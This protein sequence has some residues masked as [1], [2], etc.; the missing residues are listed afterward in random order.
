VRNDSP[1]IQERGQSL[2]QVLVVAG[3]TAFLSLALATMFNFSLRGQ[4]AVEVRDAVRLFEGEVINLLSQAETCRQN[5]SG[6]SVTSPG[7]NLTR[8]VRAD[9]S[10]MFLANQIYQNNMLRFVSAHIGAFVPDSSSEP[11]KGR[12]KLTLQLEPL[13]DPVGPRVYMRDIRILG[14]IDSTGAITSCIAVATSSDGVWQISP[15]NPNDI[16]YMAGQVGV[17]MT[18][19]SE[20]LSVAG[21]VQ[22]TSGGFKFPD[23]TIQESAGGGVPFMLL[24]GGL[25]DGAG[26]MQPAA[27]PSGWRDL[28]V[29]EQAGDEGYYDLA[30]GIQRPQVLL[31]RQCLG[32]GNRSVIYLESGFN[33]GG[34]AVNPS[35]CPT[36]WTDA[37]VGRFAGRTGWWDSTSEL[38]YPQEIRIRS[39]FK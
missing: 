31:K 2:V 28:G 11:S 5:F 19:P 34:G 36:G 18:N 14:V 12:A 30:S 1:L 29:A 20:K 8:I 15:G 21:V 26:P 24:Y 10:E 32:D 3:L 13:G 22:S 38:V 27:C 9:G 17:G 16:F 39:C 25:D 6:K 35:A 37:G 4:R 7:S 23:G 33:N